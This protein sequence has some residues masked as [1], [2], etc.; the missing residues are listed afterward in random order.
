MNNS[1]YET[2][3]YPSPNIHSSV[4]A[5]V[6]VNASYPAPP[7]T[8]AVIRS[9]DPVTDALVCPALTTL[10]SI[11]WSSLFFSAQLSLLPVSVSPLSSPNLN[12][13]LNYRPR[14]SLTGVQKLTLSLKPSATLY[15][16]S[17]RDQTPHGD[18]HVPITCP[19][20][21]PTTSSVTSFPLV[22]TDQLLF[23]SFLA[24]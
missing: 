1:S 22:M 4:S 13:P 6:S 12:L 14:T 8:H 11:S 9:A 21:S 24:F 2:Q 19:G 23:R 5:T 16:K 17:N 15:Q 3:I 18:T 20:S 10:T 7:G